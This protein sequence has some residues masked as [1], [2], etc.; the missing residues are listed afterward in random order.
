[1]RNTSTSLTSAKLSKVIFTSTVEEALW[2]SSSKRDSIKSE[3]NQTQKIRITIKI[4]FMHKRQQS[5]FVEYLLFQRKYMFTV[6][7]YVASEHLIIGMLTCTS[8]SI[9]TQQ[10]FLY[11]SFL[12]A[13]TTCEE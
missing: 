10:M 9:T 2:M 1:M 5:M 6:T 8:K 7:G 3:E 11:S 13:V 4:V 12:T